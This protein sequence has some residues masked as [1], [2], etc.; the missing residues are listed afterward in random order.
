MKKPFL[1][2]F[3]LLVLGCG[4]A[5]FPGLEKAVGL[6]VDSVPRAYGFVETAKDLAES[7]KSLADPIKA[8][9]LLGTAKALAQQADETCALVEQACELLQDVP[10]AQ[11]DCQRIETV[12]AEAL[13][14][15]TRLAPAP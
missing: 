10:E 1:L 5:K 8:K 6:V 12:K 13:A 14:L 3:P 7:A 15:L 2:M 4:D 11:A 9:D